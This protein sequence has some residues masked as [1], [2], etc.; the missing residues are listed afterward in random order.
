MRDRCAGK[1]LGPRAQRTQLRVGVIWLALVLVAGFALVELGA[2]AAY[3][4]L[5]VLPMATGMYAMLSGLF[6][7]CVFAGARGGRQADYGYEP[8]A[9]CVLRVQLRNRGVGVLFASLCWAA[10]ATAIFVASAGT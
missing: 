5:L 10:F 9:D 3:G 2:A 1:N 7:V 8:V 4:W 6:G